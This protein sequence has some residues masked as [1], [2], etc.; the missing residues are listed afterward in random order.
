MRLLPFLCLTLT[1]QAETPTSG[2]ESELVSFAQDLYRQKG[3]NISRSAFDLDVME[4]WG[5]VFYIRLVSRS[6]TLPD[7]LL[8]AFLIGGAVSQHARKPLDQIVVV[9]NVEF[10]NQKEMILR[11]NGESC[12]KLYNNRMSPEDFT[13]NWLRME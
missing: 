8:Q 3:T 1:L 9:A 12:E 10:S 6:S 4:V 2:E 7:D 5:R 13:E 11:A